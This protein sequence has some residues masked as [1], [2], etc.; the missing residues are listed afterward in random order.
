MRKS[1]GKIVIDDN[2]DASDVSRPRDDS[3][4][5]TD[6]TFS[7]RSDPIHP[8]PPLLLDPFDI[9]SE[10]Y[11]SIVTL[12]QRKVTRRSIFFLS[13]PVP[14]DQESV[15]A[16]RFSRERNGTALSQISRFLRSLSRHRRRL[17]ETE[18]SFRTRKIVRRDRIG[19]ATRGAEITRGSN[20][21]ISIDL[22]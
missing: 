14:R 22:I 17:N 6:L 19:A 9:V 11:R 13:H 1:A 4:T 12:D 21:L 20:F 5:S 16:E 3:I 10:L 2:D 18:K 15:T 8:P 7:S